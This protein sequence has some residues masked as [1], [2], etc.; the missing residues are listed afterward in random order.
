M[1]RR[2]TKREDVASVIALFKAKHKVSEIV[3][4]TGVCQRSVYRLIE[5]FKESG[6]A[7][8]P[9][10]K[11]RPGRPR[12][13]SPRTRK[14]INRQVCANPRL[15]AREI[16]QNNPQLLG[17]V[18]I[19]SIQDLLHDDLGYRSY[20]ARRKPLLTKVQKLKRL[21]FAK[22][23]IVWSEDDW[24]RVLWSDEATFTVTGSGYDRV[25]RKPHSDALDPKYTC[26]TVK[27]PD[28][29]MVWGCF[30]YFGVGELVVLPK[31][32]K[33]N[34]YVYLEL[35]C[36]HLP[37]SFDKT[38]A[39]VFMQDGAPCH[40]ARSVVEWFDDCQVP[41]F[42]DWPGNSPDINP[43]ENLWALLKRRLR[44]LD[45]S[46]VPK[47]TAALHQLWGSLCQQHLQNLADSVPRR[48]SECLKRKGN[49]TRY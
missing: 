23:Y 21:R 4:I 36:D 22:K 34:Q 26:K 7:Q 6:Y 18:S 13:T 24:R 40:T 38:Q 29:L 43:I 28:S 15:T 20:R 42:K 49:T 48:L 33:V 14:V 19:R 16:K 41:F 9:V 12:L 10:P 32:I 47:L 45:T 1:S 35:L 5:Q 3:E 31:N 11:P 30:S 39:R 44:D 2:S 17:N 46:S 27:H 8:L 37:D 25:Y